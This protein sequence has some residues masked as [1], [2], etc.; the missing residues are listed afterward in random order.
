MLLPHVVPI[1]GYWHFKS[2]AAE[3][4]GLNRI[5]VFTVTSANY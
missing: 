2:I 4:I 1:A 5:S 3:R